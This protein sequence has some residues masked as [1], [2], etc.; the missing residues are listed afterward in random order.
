[1]KQQWET[2]MESQTETMRD[3]VNQTVTQALDKK[4]LAPSDGQVGASPAQTKFFEQKIAQSETELRE[5][6]IEIEA[7]RNERLGSADA[8]SVKARELHE[9]KRLQEKTAR[10]L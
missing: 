6:N 2:I 4:H 7:L 3:L 10:D 5:K 9:T 1:M 8:D